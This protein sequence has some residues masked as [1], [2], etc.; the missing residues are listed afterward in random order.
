MKIKY[1]GFKKY[2]LIFTCLLLIFCNQISFAQ[3]MAPNEDF[4][5]EDIVAGEKITEGRGYFMKK[6]EAQREYIKE[7]ELEEDLALNSEEMQLMN[8]IKTE[9]NSRRIYNGVNRRISFIEYNETQ[10]PITRTVDARTN[11][12]V[13]TTAGARRSEAVRR[14]KAIFGLDVNKNAPKSHPRE[15]TIQPGK[16][17]YITFTPKMVEV[18]GKR[19]YSLSHGTFKWENFTSHLPCATNGQEN[20]NIYYIV[21]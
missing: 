21:K 18:R 5:P 12:P 20:G 16:M 4:K 10:D 3:D 1:P 13:S 19:L 6:E 8:A 17:F 15:I 11:I 7:K 14:V 9:V 2:V